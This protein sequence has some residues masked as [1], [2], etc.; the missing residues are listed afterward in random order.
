MSTSTLYVWAEPRGS[1]AEYNFVII[2][3]SKKNVQTHKGASM[4]P[5]NLGPKIL[6][7]TGNIRLQDKD[8]KIEFVNGATEEA[9]VVAGGEVHDPSQVR[10]LRF[11]EIIPL[12]ESVLNGS[13][14]SLR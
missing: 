10:P 6:D 4:R 7:N 13:R 3:T 11:G 12:V 5:D 14:G 9:L 1:R 8:G 2:D